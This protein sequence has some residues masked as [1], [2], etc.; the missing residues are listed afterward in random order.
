MKLI[1]ALPMM[2]LMLSSCSTPVYMTIDAYS[3][4]EAQDMKNYVFIDSEKPLIGGDLQ[5]KEFRSMTEQVLA[6]DGFS[7]TNTESADVEIFLDYG[8]SDPQVVQSTYSTPVYGPTGLL[9]VSYSSLGPS[10]AP[11]YGVVGY[12]TKVDTQIRYERY[13]AMVGYDKNN[14]QPNGNH[15]ELWRLHV[16]SVGETGDL[17]RIFPVLLAGAKNYIGKSTGQKIELKMY[18]NNKEVLKIK[19]VYQK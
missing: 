4:P 12:E 16:S 3:S 13:L 5:N 18:E 7:K 19:D 2:L 10:V 11:Q 8:V 1:Y 17:R 6:E 14:I 9:C 15:V